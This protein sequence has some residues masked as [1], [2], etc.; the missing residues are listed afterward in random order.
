M[1]GSLPFAGRA[2]G[3][4]EKNYA[5]DP[6]GETPELPSLHRTIFETSLMLRGK[7]RL[8]LTLAAAGI[9]PDV[10]SRIDERNQW[11]DGAASMTRI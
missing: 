1:T 8:G 4:R 9:Y 6:G 11:Q 2:G 7:I 3:F 5:I 10:G